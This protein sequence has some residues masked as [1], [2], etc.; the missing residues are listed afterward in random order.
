MAIEH[1]CK[2]MI[3]KQAMFDYLLVYAYMPQ[4]RTST[5]FHTYPSAHS[6]FS[7][8]SLL[9]KEDAQHGNDAAEGMAPR[10]PRPFGTEDKFSSFCQ[11]T[12]F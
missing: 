10:K 7:S 11:G 12:L 4:L 8:P 6:D 2:W 5:I 1:L 3:F 9:P